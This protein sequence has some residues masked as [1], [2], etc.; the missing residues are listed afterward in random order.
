VHVEIIR[1]S[2]TDKN[3]RACYD[4]IYRKALER[5]KIDKAF[6]DAVEKRMREIRKI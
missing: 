6:K 3:R 1:G 4:Y 2:S 5:M